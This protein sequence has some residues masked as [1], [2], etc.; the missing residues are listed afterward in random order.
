MTLKANERHIAPTTVSTGSTE[1]KGGTTVGT[2]NIYKYDAT[3]K[4]LH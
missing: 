3:T 2:E 1:N 4:K